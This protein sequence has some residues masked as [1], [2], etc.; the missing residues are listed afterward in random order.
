MLYSP[1]PVLAW[2]QLNLYYS[3]GPLG[4]VNGTS[5]SDLG[6]S[7]S[8]NLIKTIPPEDVPT[9]KQFFIKTFFLGD[10]KLWQEDTKS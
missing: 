2:V 4:P 10:L 5:N 1:A 3:L 9:D 7:A 6:L 8:T